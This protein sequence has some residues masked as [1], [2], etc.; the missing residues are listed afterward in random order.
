MTKEENRPY[1]EEEE[2][3]VKRPHKGGRVLRFE[4][5]D[6]RELLASPTAVT[7]F[8]HLG[9]YEFCEHVMLLTC[10]TIPEY[11]ICKEIYPEHK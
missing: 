7:S 3:E 5:R 4:P 11:Q 9:C 1:I 10:K 8:K 6:I 2:I